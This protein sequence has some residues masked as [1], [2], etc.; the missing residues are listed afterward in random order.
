MAP[1]RFRPR[2]QLRGSGGFAPPSQNGLTQILIQM[3]LHEPIPPSQ[4]KNP[5]SLN[6]HGGCTLFLHPQAGPLC[7]FPRRHVRPFTSRQVF[8][9]PDPSTLPPSHPLAA[10]SGSWNFVPGYSG[11]TAPDL[12]GIPSY[13]PLSPVS[14][15]ASDRLGCGGIGAPFFLFRRTGPHGLIITWKLCPNRS[16]SQFTHP[17]QGENFDQEKILISPLNKSRFPVESQLNILYF[18]NL[19]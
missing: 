11:G 5:H 18:L 14:G 10:G 16:L 7:P 8:W 6:D 2:S 3:D 19:C 4:T 9:L 17:S 13:A 1:C 12:H 15:S